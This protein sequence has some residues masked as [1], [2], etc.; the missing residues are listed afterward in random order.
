MERVTGIG[1]IFFKAQDPARLADWYRDHLG[2]VIEDSH[3]VF[4][5]REQNSFGQIGRTVWSLFP[6]DTNYFGPVSKGFMINYRVANLD[7]MLDQLRQGGAVV[8]KV[9]G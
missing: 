4:E 3:A 8:E 6:A 5:W 7:R 1:G 2:M 9:E